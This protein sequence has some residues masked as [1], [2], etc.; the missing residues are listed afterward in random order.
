MF[1][2]L[3]SNDLGFY[4]L[5]EKHVEMVQEAGQLLYA[6]V[7]N[8]KDKQ[9]KVDRILE[10]E[11]ECD[12]IAH[13][14][15]ELLHRTFITP[16]DG[17]EIHL[18]ISRLDDIMDRIDSAAHRLI[19]FEI[20]EVPQNLTEISDVLVQTIEQ[21]KKLVKLVRTVNK[22]SKY[23]EYCVE[24]HRLENEGD[25]L[26]REGIASLFRNY[27][28]DPLMVIKLKE[29]YEMI[30]VAIDTCEDVANIVETILME[31]T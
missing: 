26:H 3:V 15:I 24:I 31:H 29:I 30:E 22:S 28:N 4:D 19:L 20:N 25:R 1:K 6:A 16:L 23:K 12:S 13:L 10:I 11:H 9:G 14:T 7:Q 5:F 18:L 27:K 21:V 8:L 2:Q 17:D